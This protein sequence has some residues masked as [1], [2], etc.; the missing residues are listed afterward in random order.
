VSDHVRRTVALSLPVV[1]NRTGILLLV[2]VDTMM[3]G[4]FDTEE[5]AFYALAMAPKLPMLLFG[6]GVMM[7]TM[8]LCAQA[9]GAGQIPRTGRILRVALAMALCLGL[10]FTLICQLGEPLLLALGQQRAL[11][12]GGA[13]VLAI[14]GWGLPAILMF[15]AASYFLEVTGRPGVG[16][17]VMLLANVVN[18]LG[19]AL[20]I[21]DPAG[22]GI[23]GAQ[24]AALATTVARWLAVV[25][26]LG[27]ILVRMRGADFGLR[28]PMPAGEHLPRRLLG[29][30]LPMGLA[31]A[32][33]SGAFACLT[34]FAGWLGVL[35]VAALQIGMNFMATVFMCA[36]GISSATSIRVANAVGRGDPHGVRTAGWVGAGVATAVLGAIALVVAVLPASIAGLY[37]HDSA[38][39][40]LVVP[41]LLVAAAALVPDGLQATLMG[42]LRGVGDV[43]PATALSLVAFWGVMVPAAW[44]AGVHLRLGAPALL[45]AVA[46]GGVIAC[47][48]FSARFQRVSL[49]AVPV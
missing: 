35:H 45:A 23:G 43:W 4:R 41:T 44:Y 40:V 38:V 1:L 30:G 2:V 12:V 42:A 20:L 10:M 6:I 49:H 36:I 9:M 16:V 7:G 8:V 28:G 3:L 34:L 27:Y 47:A 31:H 21:P 17:L 18:A 11:A 14:F 29:L 22:L 24:G 39:L 26:M 46:A 5:L 19:N 48:L 15:A 13:A 37:S 33:E 25:A 32:V